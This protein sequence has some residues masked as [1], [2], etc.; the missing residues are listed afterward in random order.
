MIEK[1]E[2]SKRIGLDLSLSKIIENIQTSAY[3]SIQDERGDMAVAL[4]C[5]DINDIK[6][7]LDY[8]RLP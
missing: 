7:S 5:M 6:R 4:S 1:I 3:I 2:H 8:D